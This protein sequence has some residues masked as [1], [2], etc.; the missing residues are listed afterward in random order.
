MDKPKTVAKCK[1]CNG[2][3]FYDEMRWTQGK[4]CCRRCF[5]ELYEDLHQKP[6]T[7]KDCNG[8]FPSDEDV[9]A[10]ENIEVEDE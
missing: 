7:W 1:Y 10:S 9:R 3:E 5:K 8:P 4:H 2:Y 6:Y